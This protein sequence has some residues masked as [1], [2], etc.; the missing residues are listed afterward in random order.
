SIQSEVLRKRSGVDVRPLEVSP[1]HLKTIRE[2]NHVFEDIVGYTHEFT[3]VNDGGSVHQLFQAIVT[4]NAFN[5]YGVSPLLGREIV[6][7]DGAPDAPPVFVIG[8]KA[9][10]NEFNGDPNIVGKSFSVNGERRVCIG[11]MPAHFQAYGAQVQAWMP[12]KESPTAPANQKGS[13]YTLARLKPDVSIEAASTELDLILKQFATVNPKDFPKQ[14]TAR[15]LPATDFLMGPWGIGVA[16]AES[17]FFNT[18][19]MLYDL[20]GAV[21]VLLLIACCNV[22]NLL[23]ARATARRK[24]IAIRTALG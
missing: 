17:Q 22:A 8:Y 19:R 10:N 4:A 1:E 20:L 23:L 11:V 16:G 6:P 13:L 5:F 7:A 24:E 21:M 12:Y 14:F 3:I 18:K 2:Q 9:W 15:V